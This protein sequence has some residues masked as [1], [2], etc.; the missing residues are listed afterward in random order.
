MDGTILAKKYN[1]MNGGGGGGGVTLYLNNGQ[2][3]TSA[4][5]YI[6]ANFS[7]NVPADSELL[8]SLQDGD[9]IVNKLYKYEGG[10][11][12]FDMEGSYQV[13]MTESNIGLSYYPGAYRDMYMKVSLID[14]SQTY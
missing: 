14:P 6:T 12:Q 4:E 2:V 7:K 13:S 9:N 10:S 1:L 8:I 3:A 11:R 5:T